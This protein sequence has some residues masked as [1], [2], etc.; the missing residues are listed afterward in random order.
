MKKFCIYIS[1]VLINFDCNNFQN[2]LSNKF[3]AQTNQNMVNSSLRT[4]RVS[5]TKK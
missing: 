3:V 5:K 2:S 1:F 4:F